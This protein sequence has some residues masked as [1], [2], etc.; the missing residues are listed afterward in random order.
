MD[1]GY[2]MDIQP[3]EDCA[4][5]AA[6]ELYRFLHWRQLWGQTADRRDVTLSFRRHAINTLLLYAKMVSNS[7]PFYLLK[8]LVFSDLDAMLVDSNSS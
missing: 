5:V 4:F 3:N 8:D 2:K 1:C 7:Y 6:K